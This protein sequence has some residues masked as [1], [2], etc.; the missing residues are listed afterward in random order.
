MIALGAASVQIQRTYMTVTLPA[1]AAG[2]A[3][4]LIAPAGWTLLPDAAAGVQWEALAAGAYRLT[5][6][7]GVRTVRLVK[8]A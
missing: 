1:D 2:G 6:P 8:T 4:T 3:L 5:L 7:K